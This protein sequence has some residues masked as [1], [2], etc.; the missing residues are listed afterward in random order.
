MN[1][2]LIRASQNRIILFI[3]DANFSQQKIN[4][5]G[6]SDSNSKEEKKMKKTESEW[7]R[8]LTPEEYYILREKGTERAFTGKYD[9]HFEEEFMHVQD[10]EQTFLNQAQSMIQAVDGP[11]SM[12]LCQGLLK[13]LKIIVMGCVA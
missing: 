11:L 8:A 5:S 13:K 2:N 1:K 9:K 12:R 3:F 7:K 10:V 6:V 4:F